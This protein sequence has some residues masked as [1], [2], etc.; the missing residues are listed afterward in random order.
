MQTINEGQL[1]AD[2]AHITE[3]MGSGLMNFSALTVY[4]ED[5]PEAAC[6][7]IETFIEE[8]EKNIDIVQQALDN[9]DTDAIAAMA[10]KL[11]PLFTLIGASETIAPL[12][13]LES[14]RGEMFVD[15]IKQTTLTVLATVPHII[16]EAKEYLSYRYP[17]LF[18]K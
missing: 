3:D 8:T 11:L 16:S 12:K 5:D 15:E 6:S 1:V 10:H 4:S 13:Y 9:E 18:S 17:N 2:E 14:C 7:I